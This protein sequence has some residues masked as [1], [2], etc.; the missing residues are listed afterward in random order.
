MLNNWR[1]TMSELLK[2]FYLAYAAWLDDGA[3]QMDT[4]FDRCAGLCSNLSW[5]A[6][7]K[8]TNFKVTHVAEDQL[9]SQ[10]MQEGLDVDYPFND[11]EHSS[12]YWVES[13]SK[14]HHRNPK[15]I[16]WVRN[17]VKKIKEQ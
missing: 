8:S 12:D 7:S 5:F 11:Q 14:T 16:A 17:Q 6:G 2:A 3:P 9:R 15:R 13:N 1:R 4:V 10:F